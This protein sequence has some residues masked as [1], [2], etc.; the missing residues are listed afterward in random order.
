MRK[1]LKA[2]QPTA[3][4]STISIDGEGT[5][6]CV[7]TTDQKWSSTNSRS[8]FIPTWSDTSCISKLSSYQEDQIGFF[9][10][11]ADAAPRTHGGREVG[12]RFETLTI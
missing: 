9:E 5:E 12:L 10:S 2:D 6:M 4:L 11:R 1:E 7:F 3:V 8:L